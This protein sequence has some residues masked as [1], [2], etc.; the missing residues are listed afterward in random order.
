MRWE[1]YQG[2]LYEVECE[3]V[4]VQGYLTVIELC[5]LVSVKF[6]FAYNLIWGVFLKMASMRKGVQFILRLLICTP[7]HIV[8]FLI[9][10][11][12]KVFT[13]QSRVELLV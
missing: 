2:S 6:Y 1:E 8:F 4:S 11:L 10:S 12:V 5:Q 9:R 13:V 7:K 3:V